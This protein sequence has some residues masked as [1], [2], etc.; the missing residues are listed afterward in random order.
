MNKL[1]TLAWIIALSMV[2]QGCASLPVL[3]PKNSA[4][5]KHQAMP[6]GAGIAVVCVLENTFNAVYLGLSRLTNKA[7][8]SDVTDWQL[9]EFISGL[10]KQAIQ[11]D[12]RYQFIETGIGSRQFKKIYHQSAFSEDNYKID[13]ISEL[14]AR[15][16]F[17]YNA[18]Y[19]LLVIENTIEDPIRNT[20]SEFTGYGIYRNATAIKSS[21]L[22]SYLHALLIDTRRGRL[23]RHR[24]ITDYTKLPKQFWAEN[25]NQ[26]ADQHS[27]YLKTESL[28]MA[29]G[30]V[31]SALVQF[32]V[33]SQQVADST[34]D[35]ARLVLNNTEQP[36]NY[37]MLY[38]H[39]LNRVYKALNIEKHFERYAIFMRNRHDENVTRHFSLY[40]DIYLSWM[41]QYVNWE[42]LKSKMAQEYRKQFTA[43]E[44][45]AIADFAETRAGAK[46]LS[47][48]PLIL[49]RQED[50]WIEE[51]EKHIHIL[52][53]AVIKRRQK[54]IN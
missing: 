51:A 9:N 3:K 1:S 4:P 10:A 33:I 7:Y 13:N 35:S 11:Q 41:R 26:L 54:F 20:D 5:A 48:I 19:L 29:A 23:I 21:Y 45:H 16:A 32:D 6:P 8:Q 12:N 31:L 43:S 27:R 30:N 38:E 39:A 18:D 37:N 25:I 44:L 28:R 46:M 53:D 50:I 36:G 40:K 34:E 24:Q 17:E 2:V 14:L 49:N 15:L 52:D 47:K 22:Y 42:I